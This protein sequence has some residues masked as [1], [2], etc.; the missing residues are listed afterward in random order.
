[1]K[2]KKIAI[3]IVNWNGQ[4]LLYNCLNAVFNQSYNNFDVFFVDNGSIDKSVNFV[5]KNFPK[6]N[7]IK[8]G[9]NSGFA[10]GNNIG[11]RE[12]F[13]DND[14]K[15]IALLNNDAVP[16][17]EWLSEMHKTINKV[18]DK[19]VGMIATKTILPDGLIHNIGLQFYKNITGNKNGGCSL[20]YNKQSQIFNKDIEVPCPSGVASLFK[21]ELLEK[22]GLFDENFFVYAEDLDLGMR[23]RLAG[24][25][26]YLASKAM[27]I[28]YHS[29]TFGLASPKKIFYTKRNS[30]FVVIKNFK[31]IDMVLY[32]F[33][34]LYLTFYL[35][36]NKTT[37][38]EKLQNQLNLFGLLK[39]MFKIYY[40]VL[41]KIPVM[42]VERRRNNKN[43]KINNLL[44]NNMFKMTNY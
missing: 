8:V 2:N 44:Y 14:V 35:L 24:W 29:Y 13:K 12:A 17:K 28:H 21:R 33:R 32:P 19:Q 18:K 34:D 1:M 22:I 40:G 20:G 3:I 41:I 42:L 16:D 23:A 27:V 25:K 37:S 6:T 11:I 9:Y 31:F 38:I 36:F 4:K 5:K 26:C 30:F 15:Y 39:L 43:I 7:I 10:K